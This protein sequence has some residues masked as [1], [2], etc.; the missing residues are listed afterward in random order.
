M[1]LL[2]LCIKIQIGIGQGAPASFHDHNA[3]RIL[4]HRKQVF[5][6]GKGIIIRHVYLETISVVSKARVYISQE[7]GI[8]GVLLTAYQNGDDI[9]SGLIGQSGGVRTTALPAYNDALRLQQR[10]SGAD[11]LSAHMMLPA[12][13]RFRGEL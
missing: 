10:Q 7:S 4:K 9:A 3:G 1:A 2:Q 5:P 6:L 8:T 12:Q 13:L 11:S